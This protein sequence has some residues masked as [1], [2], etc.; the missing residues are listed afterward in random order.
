MMITDPHFKT[1]TNQYYDYHGECDM[2]L[3]QNN[4]LEIHIRT[5]IMPPGGWSTI[6]AV[7]IKIGSDVLEMSGS[8]YFFNSVFSLLPPASVGGYPVVIGSY[9]PMIVLAG[10]QKI[11]LSLYSIHVAVEVV[12]HTT[13]F[14]D[15]NGMCGNWSSYGFIGRNGTGTLSNALDFAE[16][17]QVDTTQG[18][19]QLFQTSALHQCNAVRRSLVEK[20]SPDR[21]LVRRAADECAYIENVQNRNNCNFDIL[22]TGD[23][24]FAKQKVY[25]AP[26][27]VKEICQAISTDCERKGG[28]C[29]WRC[30][31]KVYDCLPRLCK[32]VDGVQQSG[33]NGQLANVTYVEGCSC[34]VPKSPT[35]ETTATPTRRPVDTKSPVK[36][37]PPAIPTTAAPTNAPTIGP[38]G[39]TCYASPGMITFSVVFVSN[40][41]AT[42]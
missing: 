41:I 6:L 40:Y 8:G 36:T 4:L 7:A 9:G 1:W 18:D 28:K 34:A 33:G 38:S 25:Q 21:A 10:G 13:D 31:T 42:Y 3:V 32:Y 16:E 23:V 27:E 30:D 5:Q 35:M 15:S 12:G 22:M 14:Y 2:I 20:K 17:W 37:R 19:P 11:Q 39:S 24:G 29:V 26:E